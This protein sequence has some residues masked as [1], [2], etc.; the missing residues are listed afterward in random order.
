MFKYSRRPG[1]GNWLR[2]GDILIY[3]P[4]TDTFFTSAQIGYPDTEDLKNKRALTQEEEI[5]EWK[6]GIAT[7][8][9]HRKEPVFFQFTKKWP[10]EKENELVRYAH[11]LAER[12]N[13][14]EVYAVPLKTKG[15]LHGALLILMK[16][17]RALSD[18]DRSLLE[19]ISEGIAGG[20]AK[21]KA[22]EGLRL[23][24]NAL[25]NSIDPVL[26]ANMEG[27]LTYVNPAFLKIWGYNREK[28]VLG[29][30]CT[31]FLN[32]EQGAREILA[33]V[34]EKGYWKG[35]LIGMRKDGSRF[36]ARLFA[37][38]VIGKKGPLQ[39]IAIAEPDKNNI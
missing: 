22:E 29:R 5:E 20:I 21:I 35:K 3:S 37:S 8:A 36:N 16:S 13:P 30:S 26:M 4:E 6:K 27:K 33:V 38:L 10:N 19:G 25:E 24:A 2:Y 23:K 1:R 32:R 18:E 17:G 39:F 34:Q 31:A 12:Y 7:V 11:D 14:Q 15:E 28:E 9:I